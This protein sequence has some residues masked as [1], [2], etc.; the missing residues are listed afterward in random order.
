MKQQLMK[1]ADRRGFGSRLRAL[2]LAA[3][4]DW[5]QRDFRDNQHIALVFAS[6]LDESSNYLDVGANSGYF[7]NIAARCAPNGRHIAYEPVPALAANLK[8]SFPQ[9]DIRQAALSTARGT[10]AFTVDQGEPAFS[11]LASIASP[12]GHTTTQIEVRVEA[13]DE[14]LPP[15]WAARLIKIDAEGAEA[16]VIEGGVAFLA[17]C[18]PVIIFELGRGATQIHDMLTGEL[19]MRVFDIDGGGPYSREQLEEALEH[20][21]IWN[22]LAH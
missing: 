19:A 11:R 3:S 1:L 2:K 22:F 18:R 14:D 13:L 17:R 8:R 10:A 15:D 16:Q 4:P 21:E 6:V 12:D 9:V 5:V 7:V 20:G